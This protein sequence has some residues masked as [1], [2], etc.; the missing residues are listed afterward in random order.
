MPKLLHSLLL[1]A[2]GIGALQLLVAL[3]VPHGSDSNLYSAKQFLTFQER[4]DSWKPMIAAYHYAAAEHAIPLYE[5]IFFRQK[6]KFQYPP[7]SLIIVPWLEQAMPWGAGRARFTSWGFVV[8]SGLATW[9]IL[10]RGAGGPAL[11][12]A[13]WRV[14]AG[15]KL[16]VITAALTAMDYPIVRA[17]ALGQVQTWINGLVAVALW[18]WA[19]QGRLGAG[20]LVGVA[21]LIKPTYA[22][23]VL[24]GLLRRQMRFCAGAALALIAGLSWSIARFGWRDHQDYLR[25]LSFLSR[26]GE[27][28]HANQSVNGLLNR[29]FLN[30]AEWNP[31]GF[32]PYHAVVYAGT[33][34]GSVLL[35]G[36][37]LRAAYARRARAPSALEFSA[38]LL[39]ATMASPIAWEHHYGILLPIYALLLLQLVRTGLASDPRWVIALLTSYLLTSIA[40]PFVDVSARVPGLNLLQSHLFFGALSLLALLY[41]VDRPPQ[42]IAERD[43][44]RTRQQP[45]TA[46]EME[47]SAGGSGRPIR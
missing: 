30:G 35:I 2:I 28:F 37:L 5:E 3:F 36:V 42:P 18:L 7:S 27:G 15:L 45:P 20:F 19:V 23:V 39:T 8:L 47:T 6:I 31:N 11:S 43:G 41:A 16:A 14:F 21:C 25:A 33:V 10:W 29:L 13:R 38:A 1:I 9:L 40:F 22:V 46:I 24:W 32:P 44:A 4:R 17:Y 26:H 12:P 34:L